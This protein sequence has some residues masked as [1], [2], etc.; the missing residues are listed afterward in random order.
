MNIL[1]ISQVSFYI[2]VSIGV[3][4]FSVLFGVVAY[5]LIR[6]TKNLDSVS[7]NFK[8]A[9]DKLFSLPILSFF[10]KKNKK[11]YEKK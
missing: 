4:F 3:I 1:T 2:I 11:K 7:E 8:D 5:H 10:K 9:S 6:I